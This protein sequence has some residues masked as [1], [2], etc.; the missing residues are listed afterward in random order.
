MKIIDITDE[1]LD[2]QII[3][4]RWG[5]YHGS[6]NNEYLNHEKEFYETLL[7]NK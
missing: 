1:L 4:S 2:R 3:L 5:K 6:D 7:R